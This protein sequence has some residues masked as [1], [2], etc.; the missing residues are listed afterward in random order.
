MQCIRLKSIIETK[1]G[2]IHDV[3]AQMQMNEQKSV[4][5]KVQEFSKMV[6]TYLLKGGVIDTSS[7][8]EDVDQVEVN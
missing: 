1:P 2:S 8:H 7:V 4:S 6:E 3:V 5:I